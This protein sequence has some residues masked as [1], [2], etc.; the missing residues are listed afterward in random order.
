MDANGKVKAKTAGTVTITASCNGKTAAYKVKVIPKR[1]S[2]KKVVSKSKGKASLS[3]K[4]VT[5]ATGYQIQVSYKKGSWKNIKKYTVKKGKITSQ[6]ISRLKAGRKAFVRIRAYQK[7]SGKTYY[8]T[9][10]KVKQVKIKK[11]SLLS[12]NAK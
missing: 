5:K 6:T 7:V 9:W 4:K 8:G 10:S 12:E 2:W 3:W 1:V 11:N